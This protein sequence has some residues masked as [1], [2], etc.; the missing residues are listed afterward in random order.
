V[1]RPEPDEDTARAITALDRI[2]FLLERACEPTYRV[3]A[4]RGAP[5]TLADLPP[6]ELGRRLAAGTLRQLRGIGDVTERTIAEAVRGETPVYQRRLEATA[7]RPVAEGG[8]ELRRALRGDLHTHS[9]WSDGGSP[10]A[11]MA[12]AAIGLGHEYIALTDHSPRLTVANGLSP[13]RLREQLD[14]LAA[15]N[16]EL[17]PFRVLTG[18]EVDILE[19]GS[20]DQS[21]ELLARLDVVVASVHS[22]LRMPRAEMT[23][24][25]VTAVRNPHTDVLGHCTGR[26]VVGQRGRPESE[27]DPDVVFAEC[28]RTG[29]AV[30][31]NSR[32]E[33][34]DPPKRLLRLAVEAGC[35]VT[36]DTD[37]HAPGQLDWQPYGCERAAACGVDVAGVVNARPLA[38]LLE[39]TGRGE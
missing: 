30:E 4:F 35:L 27:F 26:I 1:S 10:I 16:T 25:M 8:A 31:V 38:E 14:V 7:G 33:R 34:L 3:R 20:L 28:A 11:E 17:A 32:P 18:I 12:R 23:A 39:W 37:A 5:S 29:V 6:G 36:I 13:D 24:R 21:P 2:A 22:K 19:D 15:L 9:D